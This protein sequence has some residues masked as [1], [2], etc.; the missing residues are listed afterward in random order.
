MQVSMKLGIFLVIA[1]LFSGCYVHYPSVG[2]PGDRV[3]VTSWRGET[4]IRCCYIVHN[5]DTCLKDYDCQDMY[6]SECKSLQ[7]SR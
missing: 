4:K 5:I 6:P 1:C 7:R 3:R 2:Y